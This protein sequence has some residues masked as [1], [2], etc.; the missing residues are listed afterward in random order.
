MEGRDKGREKHPGE[1]V[2]RLSYKELV[3]DVDP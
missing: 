3:V 1:G 2:G